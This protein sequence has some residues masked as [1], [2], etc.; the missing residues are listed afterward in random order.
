MDNKLKSKK[1]LEIVEKKKENI[2]QE[3]N[4]YNAWSYDFSDAKTPSAMMY[5]G[6]ENAGKVLTCNGDGYIVL[7]PAQGGEGGYEP[8]D[9]TIGL[10]ANL[11]LYVKDYVAKTYVD[12]ALEDVVSLSE[13]QTIT[14]RKA[15]SKPIG[16]GP[17]E[18]GIGAI[19]NYSYIQYSP[20]NGV[21][22]YNIYFPE[23]SG[24][25]ALEDDIPTSYIKSIVKSGDV[26]TAT[27]Q[28]DTTISWS[29]GSGE[30]ATVYNITANLDYQAEII[31]ITSPSYK[32]AIEAFYD[33]N[34]FYP[35]VK[36][37]LD[38]YV[39]GSV[40]QTG[41]YQINDIQEINNQ[42]HIWFVKTE[43]D[44]DNELKVSQIHFVDSGVSMSATFSDMTTE[45]FDSSKYYDS[46][47]IDEGFVDIA[48][49]Q[50]IT[51]R[52]TFTSFVD[53][54][55]QGQTTQYGKNNIRNNIDENTHYDYAFPEKS[56]TFAM[57]SDIPS[58]NE[59][60]NHITIFDCPVSGGGD[61]TN[62][63]VVI[64]SKQPKNVGYINDYDELLRTAIDVNDIRVYDKSTGKALFIKDDMYSSAIDVIT[65]DEG[66]GSSTHIVEIGVLAVNISDVVVEN[67]LDTTK[68]R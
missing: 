45:T 30:G 9:E 10:N 14:G 40:V 4:K 1:E 21:H 22:K 18:H 64:N 5:G 23:A 31:T 58:T 66:A 55:Y 43:L 29:E 65:I 63:R 17:D 60:E 53:V 36:L 68:K 42:L 46:R 28:D 50:T 39:S 33:E 67:I 52:K 44:E 19:L 25:L 2:E 41:E 13:A 12:E 11:E 15:F 32:T 61:L 37:T 57:L 56:G 24:T 48:N 20:D 16:V 51:G 49:D 59:Y 8:D 54:A 26:Y 34:G 35:F 6:V 3:T 38:V 62:A 27:R 47:E 7:L